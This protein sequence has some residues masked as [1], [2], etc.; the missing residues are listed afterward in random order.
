VDKEIPWHV[1]QFYP[2]YKLLDLPRIPIA[3][4]R[5]AREIVLEVGLRYVYEGNVTGEAGESTYCYKCGKLLIRR[6]GYQILE[7]R[8]ENSACSYCGVKIDGVNV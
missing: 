1:S 6:Y 3:T 5:R 7:N 2:M 8:V 4:L